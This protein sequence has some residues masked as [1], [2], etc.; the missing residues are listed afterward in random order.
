MFVTSGAKSGGAT[1]TQAPPSTG[2]LLT[3]V[4]YDARLHGPIAAAIVP[5]IIA[6]YEKVMERSKRALPYMLE[7][8]RRVWQADI[9]MNRFIPRTR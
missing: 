5:V 1:R 6:D 8:H 7:A 2:D 9:G 3:I 4:G